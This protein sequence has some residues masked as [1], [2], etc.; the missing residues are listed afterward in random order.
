MKE[1]QPDSPH[2]EG[3]APVDD[4]PFWRRPSRDGGLSFVRVADFLLAAALVATAFLF[5]CYELT[6]PDLWWHLRAGDW[7]LETR[8]APGLDPF[9]FGSADRV[10]VDLHWLF[11]TIVASIFHKAGVAGVTLLAA[12]IASA[13]ILTAVWGSSRSGLTPVAIGCWIVPLILFGY[14]LDPRPEIFSLLF[15]A[16]YLATLD[17]ASQQPKRVWLLPPVQVLW[18][19]MHGLFVL[20]P[21]VFALFLIARFASRWVSS[22][23]V[24]E[25]S[26]LADGAAQRHYAAAFAAVLAACL[27]NPYGLQGA[28]F[29]LELFPKIADSANEY[30]TYIDEFL[31]PFEYAR[32]SQAFVR[33]YAVYYRAM[34]FLWLV[35]P[36]SFA[37][38]SLWRASQS[39]AQVRRRAA[40]GER[41]AVSARRGTWLA[42]AGSFLGLLGGSL[43]AVDFATSPWQAYVGFAL[44]AAVACCWL[45][46]ANCLRTVSMK[47]A[48]IA[49]LSGAG[50][51]LTMNYLQTALAGMHESAGQNSGMLLLVLACW[52]AVGLLVVRAGADLFRLLLAAAFAY[53]SFQ[54]MRN[55]N[56]FA[57]ASGVVLSWN[58]SDWVAQ[59][60]AER[61]PTRST[62]ATV[63][64]ARGAV[65]ALFAVWLAAIGSGAWNDQ[66]NRGHRLGVGELAGEFAHDAAR[67]AGRKG[68]PDR[69]IAFDLG[70]ASLYVY[71]NGPDKKA[72]MDPRLEVPSLET[73]KTYVAI[74]DSLHG[75]G[76]VWR[77]ALEKLGRPLVLLDHRSHT[78]GEALLLT[79]G[80]W[81]CIY[82]DSLGSVFVSNRSDVS[83]RE[84]PA[85]DIAR[86]H[87]AAGDAPAAQGKQA[88]KLE[89]EALIRL[90]SE[91]CPRPSVAWSWRIPSQWLALDR[92]AQASSSTTSADDMALRGR[93]YW[94]MV[95]D[96]SVA[97]PRPAEGWHNGTGLRWAQ[98]TWHFQQAL[99]LE[100]EHATSL[101]SLYDT[102]RARRMVDAQRTAGLQLLAQQGIG[103]QQRQEIEKLDQALRPLDRLQ[104]EG[105]DATE[106]VVGDLIRQGLAA[107]AAEWAL[108]SK[109]NVSDWD[110]RIVDCLAAAWMHLGRPE[111][112]R[113][114]WQEAEHAPSEAERFSRLGDAWWVEDE[115][116]K[117]AQRYRRALEI[118]PKH[119]DALW[120]LA[121]LYAE[122]GQADKTRA[123]CQEALA[124]DLPEVREQ[125][126]RAILSIV[127]DSQEIAP[128]TSATRARDG[129]TMTR[130]QSEHKRRRESA[131]A[132]ENS[133][134]SLAGCRTEWAISA[135]LVLVTC[136]AYSRV[137]DAGFLNYDDDIYVY[138]NSHVTAGLTPETALWAATADDCANWHP[139]TWLSLQ[140][141]AQLFGMSPRGFHG[142][143]LLLHAVN[144]VLLFWALRI[145]TD[146]IGR[147][148][149]VAAFF[150]LH[151]LH[152]ES[153]AWV[154]ERKD[155]LSTLF[156]M[157]T[158]LAYLTYVAR[159]SGRRYL[160]VTLSLALGLIAK[161]MLVTLPCVL[162]LL[163]YWP[164]GRTERTEPAALPAASEAAAFERRRKRLA[165]AGVGKAAMVRAQRRV[166]RCDRAGAAP[167]GRRAVDWRDVFYRS[168]DERVAG[169]RQL[170]GAVVLAGESGGISTLTR[171]T[172][173][174][175]GKP[176]RRASCCWRSV[177]S[178]S[179]C[180]G[181]AP[182]WP[183]V[184][185]GIWGPCFR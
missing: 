24:R 30:K 74:D 1:R 172:A 163:D 76:D 142:M 40:N 10:W 78:L 89:S 62:K 173:W 19:N 177:G 110:W 134:R 157:L 2:R 131:S 41:L 161:P 123:A 7:I 98:A 108:S 46:G 6:D 57:L 159:P 117:A 170:P 109:A 152:V 185:A 54:A 42:V 127:P 77:D 175:R 22:A 164:L 167:S 132:N 148:A 140:L 79:E 35:L 36:L 20:G 126:L 63:W 69:A 112:A 70:M 21:I 119:A 55:L 156:W 73:F 25:P 151:P 136:L 111:L 59:M 171:A 181:V 125:E 15:L 31:G 43:T 129:R 176:L 100:P 32:R 49:A 64:A 82:F 178:L 122:R 23:S 118:E 88:A 144:S 52:T 105:H 139:L 28:L 67:F 124:C 17:R 71:H 94:N 58:L 120:A 12:T 96:F 101:R 184:G 5:A 158:L 72:F 65:A 86:R 99:R 141:D 154:A 115:L 130:L 39:D 33:S 50:Q 38:P 180:G 3:E 84:F 183:S 13:A 45:A 16:V 162:L 18:V 138:G 146:A 44:S 91:L 4:V 53:L 34:F 113:A 114:L 174:R 169:I 153:V 107:T 135:L 116:D 60:L 145:M 133:P 93:C 137:L 85:V 128:P 160:L 83:Q 75:R 81:R 26:P 95:T 61:A 11:E 121:M 66:V 97:P 48:A 90:G 29:P 106:A 87:F 92:L 182:T 165:R 147:S 103:P 150:A 149:C 8:S 37:V 155:V 166:E 47:A 51:A 14:R 27:L 179:A 143:N 104:R 80:D 9:T 168:R 68:L 102:W 56:L